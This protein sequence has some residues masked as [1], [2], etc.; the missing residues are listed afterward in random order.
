MRK[1]PIAIPVFVWWGFSDRL[2]QKL[3]TKPIIINIQNDFI[4]FSESEKKNHNNIM[5][6]YIDG[7]ASF[8]L[9][10]YKCN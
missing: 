6:V 9:F 8:D 1:L 5:F 3:K 4:R 2:I 7:E 10:I